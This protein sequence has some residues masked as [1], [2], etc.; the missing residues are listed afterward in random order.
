MA[1]I[2]WTAKALENLENI[3]NYI[4]DYSN[5]YAEKVIKEILNYIKILEN[6]PEVGKIIHKSIYTYRRLLHKKYIIIYNIVNSKIFI[7]AVYHKSKLITE[8]DFI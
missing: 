3:Y 7:C 4:N 2:K 5:L 1:E 6:Y 8:I